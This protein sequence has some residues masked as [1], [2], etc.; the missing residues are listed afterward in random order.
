MK[1][2]LISCAN[3]KAAN[4]AAAKELYISDLF[5][6][7]WVYAQKIKPDRIYI[8]SAKHGLL[9]PDKIIA[10]YNVTLKNMPSVERKQWAAKVLAQMSKSGLDLKNDDFIILAG[11]PYYKDII[12]PGKIEKY[13]IPMEGLKIG[14]KKSYL[15][16]RI[17]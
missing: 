5:K 13:Q 3:K 7:S 15:K 16:Q 2:V 6:K 4:N 17:D 14:C 8:L 1:I 11:T 10:P 9:H 12:G